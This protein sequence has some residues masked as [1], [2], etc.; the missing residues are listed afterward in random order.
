M[1]PNHLPGQSEAKPQPPT[2][3][4]AASVQR[5]PRILNFSAPN[6]GA[7]SIPIRRQEKLDKIARL[8]S[9][10][11]QAKAQLQQQ[12][13]CIAVSDRTVIHEVRLSLHHIPRAVACWRSPRSMACC[14][15]NGTGLGFPGASMRVPSDD[16]FEL[17]NSDV[18]PIDA[19]CRSLLDRSRR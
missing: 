4:A 15:L 3:G 6:T 7:Q 10:P 13:L 19:R 12:R 5:K 14:A 17:D 9:N 18:S 11:S 1:P 8:N 2:A 16:G